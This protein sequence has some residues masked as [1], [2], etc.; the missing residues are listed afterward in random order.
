MRNV[1][2]RRLQLRKAAE[3]ARVGRRSHFADGD[4]EYLATNARVSW[5]FVKLLSYLIYMPKP[6]SSPSEHHWRFKH[7]PCAR[8]MSLIE[9]L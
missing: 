6:P 8:V 3:K 2:K 4:V 1:V 5:W 9:P 7:L